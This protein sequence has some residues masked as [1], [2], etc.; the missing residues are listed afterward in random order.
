M[1]YFPSQGCFQVMR[2]TVENLDVLLVLRHLLVTLIS[3]KMYNAILGV[4]RD[5]A[6]MEESMEWFPKREN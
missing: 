5:F 2:Q 1:I 4:Y 6:F 3:R